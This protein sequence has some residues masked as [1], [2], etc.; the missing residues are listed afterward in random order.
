MPEKLKCLALGFVALGSVLSMRRHVELSAE[1]FISDRSKLKADFGKVAGD[2]ARGV[3]K[4]H[5]E[6]SRKSK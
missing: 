5:D 1:P 2:L 6:Q 3:K 4:V